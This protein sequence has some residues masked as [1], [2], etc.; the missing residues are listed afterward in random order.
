VQEIIFPNGNIYKGEVKDGALHGKG[1]YAFRVR[2]LIS[3]NDPFD[4]Y[5]EPG[6]YLRGEWH[7]GELY[8][9]DLYDSKGTFISKIVIGK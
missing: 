9:G 6:N 8:Y 1:I 7:E 4:R 2:S 3:N 5:A